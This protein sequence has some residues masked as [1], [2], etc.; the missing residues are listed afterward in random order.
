MICD[1]ILFV[2]PLHFEKLRKIIGSRN[3][4]EEALMCLSVKTKSSII[5]ALCFV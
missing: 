3:N 1:K 5:S 2:A 4:F